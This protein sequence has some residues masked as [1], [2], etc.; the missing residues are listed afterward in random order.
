MDLSGARLEAEQPPPAPAVG[1]AINATR[2]MEM[3]ARSKK[4]LGSKTGRI[5]KYVRYMRG[6]RP[7]GLMDWLNG[8]KQDKG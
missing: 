2:K 7:Y 6:K 1:Q 4:C 8:G 3:M 5:W